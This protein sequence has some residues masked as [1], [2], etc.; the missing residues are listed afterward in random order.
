MVYSD[1]YSEILSKI[2]HI[3]TP[4]ASNEILCVFQTRKSQ[5]SPKKNKN[6]DKK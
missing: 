2:F 1:I 5:K 3:L 4:F 6:N